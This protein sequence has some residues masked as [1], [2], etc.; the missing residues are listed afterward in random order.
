MAEQQRTPAAWA[1]SPSRPSLARRLS[2]AGSDLA[3]VR[4]ARWSRDPEGRRVLTRP[5]RGPS[6]LRE[7]RHTHLTRP[8]MAVGTDLHVVG[9]GHLDPERALVL[10][11]NHQHLRDADLVRAALPEPLARATLVLGPRALHA[12]ARMPRLPAAV[13]VGS[14]VLL[15][16]GD[17]A[18]SLDGTV[19]PFDPAVV[20][21]A[22]RRRADLVPV[23]VRG[24]FALPSPRRT[25]GG[26]LEGTPPRVSVRFAAPVAAT[27][28]TDAELA[29]RLRQAVVDL[30]DEDART[31]WEGLVG[32][33][34]Q[35]APAATWRRIWA[36]TAP[37]AA[38][39][40]GGER[41]I[42]R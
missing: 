42:W 23:A 33:P 38:G 9:A 20:Q 26:A 40:R 12:A 11:A 1:T 6:V 13:T 31:W 30:L 21:L 14:R 5:R 15:V 25:V 27:G 3:L 4:R 32:A 29:E 37:A 35:P 16:F 24:T 19:G 28:G 22:R 39:G 36:A 18:P 41:R 8:L 7:W 17:G 10:V 34:P 2:G